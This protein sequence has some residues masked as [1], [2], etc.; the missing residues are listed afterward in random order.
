MKPAPFAF[1]R[2]RSREEVDRLLAEHGDEA[3]LLAG[4]QSLVPILNMRLA[5][6]AHLID[7][8]GLEGEPR[9]PRLDGDA[10]AFAPMVRQAAA[11]RSAL[12]ADAA[13]VMVE[14]LSYVAHAP[15]R[16]RGTVVGSVAH[17]DPAA[18][19]PAVLLALGGEAR[20]R[21][22]GGA[23]AVA[24]ADLLVA[25]LTTSLEPTEWIEEVR[26]PR[27]PAGAGTAVEEQAR[28]SGDFALCG[29]IA[30]ATQAGEDAATVALTYYGLGSL[31]QR[32]ELSVGD[33]ERAQLEEAIG[34][35]A[36]DALEIEA[37]L[38]AT[39]ELRRLLARTLGARAA[40]RALERMERA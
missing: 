28:R 6:P 39:V 23:R 33:G 20:V 7:L 21:G 17:A 38:H 14:A 9:A 22:A 12:V 27:Q 11:E 4:G 37:D 16:T 34:A 26:I 18:E 3:K 2:P 10:L 13:P 36:Q 5:E 31:A 8:G 1:H 30:V 19:L 25:P 29:V 15:I 35:L 40:H 24:G 32:V